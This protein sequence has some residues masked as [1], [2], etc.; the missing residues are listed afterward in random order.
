MD[1]S[2]VYLS[3]SCFPF[4][5]PP[6]FSPSYHTVIES[7]VG[8][9]AKKKDVPHLTRTYYFRWVNSR[10]PSPFSEQNICVVFVLEG[11]EI[12]LFVFLRHNLAEHQGMRDLR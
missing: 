1:V 5:L 12:L 10:L 6:V 7:S 4:V 9:V 2:F 3:V 11:F 8:T